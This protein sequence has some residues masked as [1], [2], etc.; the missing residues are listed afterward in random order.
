MELPLVQ[1]GPS[2]EYGTTYFGEGNRIIAVAGGRPATPPPNY[3][4]A[5]A[6]SLLDRLLR[7]DRVFFSPAAA[8]S[9]VLTHATGQETPKRKPRQS[10]I[11]SLLTQLHHN[12][13]N[14][15]CKVSQLTLFERAT[16][17]AK[18]HDDEPHSK[19]T[20][21][22]RTHQKMPER[23]RVFTNHAG[24]SR[25]NRRQ[26]GNGIRT[27]RSVNPQRRINERSKQSTLFIDC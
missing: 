14:V 21:S 19:T 20:R 3:R 1:L 27:N 12:A 4:S 16:T 9:E 2:I 23:S 15:L 13:E 11:A 24:T 22:P 26:Q 7:I 18:D 25:A 5:R 8:A 10:K 17:L 6:K